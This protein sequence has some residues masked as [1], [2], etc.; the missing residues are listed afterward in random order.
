MAGHPAIREIGDPVL[1]S[2]CIAVENFDDPSLIRLVLSMQ[3]ILEQAGG[4]GLAAPQVGSL[5]RVL[6]YRLPDTQ[7]HQ[8]LLNPQIQPVSE[9][10]VPALE[11]CLS[12]PGIQLPVLRYTQIQVTAHDIAGEQHTFQAQDLEARVL[13]H[14]TDHLN[15]ILI[16]DRVSPLLRREALFALAGLGSGQQP[17]MLPASV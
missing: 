5:R 10:Q 13:Q 14:E 16:L 9:V 4:I 8:I 1:R 2:S 12:I 6:I 11:G 7:E 17:E 15:G 3:H